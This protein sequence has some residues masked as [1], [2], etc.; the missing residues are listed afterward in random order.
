MIQYKSVPGPV[1]ITISRKEDFA[2]AVKQY[3]SIIDREAVGGWK[4]EC[5]RKIPVTKKAGCLASL[6]GQED[7]TVYMNMLV[8]SKD[9]AMGVTSNSTN[10]ADLSNLT[11]RDNILNKGE[12]TAQE[13]G[14]LTNTATDHERNTNIETSNEASVSAGKIYRPSQITGGKKTGLIIAATLAVLAIIIG[15]AVSSSNRSNNNYEYNGEEY[16]DPVYKD[17]GEVSNDAR[18]FCSMASGIWVDMDTVRQSEGSVMF[19]FLIIQ[20]GTMA[21]GSYP[22]EYSRS[23]QIVDATNCDDGTIELTVFYPEIN[24]ELDGYFEPYTHTYIIELSG[25]TLFLYGYGTWRFVYMGDTIDEAVENISGYEEEEPYN[26]QKIYVESY[27]QSAIL[28]LSEYQNGDWVKLL[29]VDAQIGKNGTSYDKREGDKCTPAGTFNVLYYISTE[30]VNTEL[31]YIEIDN[32]DVWICDPDS[33]YYNTMQDSDLPSADWNSSLNE[34]LYSKFKGGYSVAC[35]MFD[36]NGDGISAGEA[37]TNRG[38]D[39]FID[40]VGPN[41]NISSGYGDI[42]INASD[43]YRLLGYLDS[44]KNPILI[45][46]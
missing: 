11:S 21:T 8:F 29:S 41:G 12:D 23:G 25:N 27:G 44:S 42:K 28:T 9:D 22:G 26:R 30:S 32:N 1:G 37:Y 3:A 13:T 24:N 15:I 18:L 4:F 33:Y 2:S 6:L 19:D 34:S 7:V 17:E 40:G 16:I 43:M 10:I 36:Y 20:D 35:I 31:K 5:I 14:H 38:S 39:I 46:E 45:V